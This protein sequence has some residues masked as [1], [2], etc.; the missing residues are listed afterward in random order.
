LTSLQTLCTHVSSVMG[1]LYEELKRPTAEN[2]TLPS[3]K[4]PKVQH[5]E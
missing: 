1:C 3:N 5:N 4:R 2:E